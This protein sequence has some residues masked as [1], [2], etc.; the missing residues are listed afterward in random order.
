M[1]RVR[2]LA[3]TAVMTAAAAFGAKAQDLKIGVIMS[4]TGPSAFVGVPVVNGIRIAM[5]DIEKAKL[6]GDRKISW[7]FQDNRS[8]KNETST[9]INRLVRSDDVLMV[10]GPVSSAEALA[11][12]PLA[13]DLK[14]PMFTTGTSPQSLQ[15][16]PYIFKSTENADAIIA[17]L[18]EYTG[19]TLKPKSCYLVH[20]R[21]ND[22]YLLYSNIFAG[23][24]RKH[25]VTVA[26]QDSILSSDSDFTALATKITTSGAD[27]LYLSTPPENG[28]NILVQARQAGLPAKTLIVGNQNMI[29]PGYVRTGGKAVEGTYIAA[30]FAAT[31]ENAVTKD[32]VAKYRERYKVL[33]D[34]WAG[35]GYSMA[36]I[37][38]TAVKNAGDKP[39]RDQVRDAMASSSDVPVVI[40][41]GKWSLNADRIPSF[42][43]VLLRI[44]NGVAV[45]VK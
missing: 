21:D 23:I 43:S 13:V 41:R 19:S 36:I 9:L 22:A 28:A 24:L 26:A 12:A 29:S 8:D 25:G 20:I 42:G 15:A 4:T 35:I 38:A 31:N 34:S 10:I 39:T 32:F 30:E 3:A 2:H 7:I 45:P 17:P 44:E 18:A 14:V 33:P 1:K 37:A 5:E 40:G 16:G 11:A 6:L 27:C